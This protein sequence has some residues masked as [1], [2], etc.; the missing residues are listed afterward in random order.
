MTWKSHHRRADVLRE[1]VRTADE[2]TVHDA[3]QRRR[4]QA[5]R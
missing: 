4:E 1:V 3:E 2:R 5:G